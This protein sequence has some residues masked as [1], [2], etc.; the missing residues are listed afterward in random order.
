MIIGTET[1]LFARYDS[2]SPS[3]SFVKILDLD[4]ITQIEL[5]P[6]YDLFLILSGIFY[7]LTAR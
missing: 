2:D 6:T 7:S 4:R 3:G 5:L 1:G